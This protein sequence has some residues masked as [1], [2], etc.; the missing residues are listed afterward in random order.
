MNAF[1]NEEGRVVHPLFR[2]QIKDNTKPTT[3]VPTSVA[4][5]SQS[6]DTFASALQ[7]PKMDVDNLSK[8]SKKKTKKKSIKP[9]DKMKKKKKKKSSDE[10]RHKSKSEKKKKKK[11]PKS[12]IKSD[13]ENK[14]GNEKAIDTKQ[15]FRK[16]VR[17]LKTLIVMK[18]LFGIE[19]EKLVEGEKKSDMQYRKRTS[20]IMAIVMARSNSGKLIY[21]WD[22][23]LFYSPLSTEQIKALSVKSAFHTKSESPPHKQLQWPTDLEKLCEVTFITGY[24]VSLKAQCFY[25]NTDIERFRYDECQLS[26][27][28]SVLRHRAFL[29]TSFLS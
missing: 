6:D 7:E 5:P 13:E 24:E 1:S 15:I 22:T 16:N 17:K 29:T 18:K 3:T 8:I 9:G 12:K 25:N 4:T 27:S 26:L 28:Q 19:T 20:D 14:D 2:T 11:E 21:D 23:P 10:K